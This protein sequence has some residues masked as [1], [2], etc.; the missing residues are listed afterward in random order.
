MY[1]LNAVYALAITFVK[2]SILFLYRRIF[3]T[4]RF[5]QVSVGIATLVVI[6]W[7]VFT[8]CTLLPCL[9][10]QKF[11]HPELKGPCFNYDEFFL[12]SEIVDILLDFVI[13]TL[14][15]RMISK[16]QMSRQ[17]KWILYLIFLVGGGYVRRK[18]LFLGTKS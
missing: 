17:R 11:W 2:L 15:V 12:G 9:P 7:I 3:T 8:I 4:P 6:W 1:T 14:P 13:L 10:P 18:N 16:L 5:R